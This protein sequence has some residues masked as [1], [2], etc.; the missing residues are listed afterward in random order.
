MDSDEIE[1]LERI[2]E[3]WININYDDENKAILNIIFSHSNDIKILQENCMFYQINS[4]F[5]SV[6]Y[7]FDI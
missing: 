5:V 6:K 3:A 1:S 2:K 4:N 7:L